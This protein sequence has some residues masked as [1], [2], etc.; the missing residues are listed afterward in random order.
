[1]SKN[2]FSWKILG[3]IVIPV[4]I[5]MLIFE[6]NQNSFVP[7][8]Q[9]RHGMIDL[10]SKDLNNRFLERFPIVSNFL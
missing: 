1:M 3:M 10:V 5:I 6:N 8:I 4:A 9:N 2:F 7:I